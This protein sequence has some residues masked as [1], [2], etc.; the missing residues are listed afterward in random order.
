M[1]VPSGVQSITAIRGFFSSSGSSV[2][3]CL[4]A[5]SATLTLYHPFLLVMSSLVE[6][7]LNDSTEKDSADSVSFFSSGVSTGGPVF[8][9]GLAGFGL[10]VG[11][12]G[13]PPATSRTN[14]SPCF[15]YAIHLRSSDQRGVRPLRSLG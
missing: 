6:S 4:R 7:L 2:S 9:S 8:S 1:P 11:L 3:T 13:S 12:R 10:G 14:T 15:V 5:P